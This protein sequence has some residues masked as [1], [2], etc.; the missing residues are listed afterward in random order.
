MKLVIKKTKITCQHGVN[1]YLFICQSEVS[2]ALG[3]DVGTHFRLFVMLH[4]K[5]KKKSG[6]TGATQHHFSFRGLTQQ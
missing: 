3:A 4:N 5:R 2:A 6:L 1:H